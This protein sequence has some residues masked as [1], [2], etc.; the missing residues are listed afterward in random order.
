MFSSTFPVEDY[1]ISIS[2]RIGTLAFGGTYSLTCTVEGVSGSP[3]T[4]WFGPGGSV[5][6]TGVSSPTP[7]T[8][9]LTFMDLALSDAGEYTCRSTI[10]GVV[11]EVVEIVMLQSKFLI[12]IGLLLLF[13]Y[14]YLLL[15]CILM[16]TI[17][18]VY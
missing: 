12:H 4:Q 6:T 10:S 18:I 7:L 16:V 3:T 13:Q 11:R 2:D 1:A 5:I 14:R 17:Y 9:T 8:S 15:F